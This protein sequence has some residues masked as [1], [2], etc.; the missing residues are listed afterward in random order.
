[1]RS[2]YIDKLV[3]NYEG[4]TKLASVD[5]FAEDDDFKDQGVKSE[6]GGYGYDGAGRQSPPMTAF[7]IGH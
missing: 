2:G 7:P 6:A 1:M 4:G 3:Y 5:D